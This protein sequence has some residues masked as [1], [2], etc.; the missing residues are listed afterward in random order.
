MTAYRVRLDVLI[1]SRDLDGFTDTLADELLKLDETGDLGGSLAT[2][3]F[4]IWTTVEAAD[5]LDAAS[6]GA[7]NI[8]CAAHAAGGT[9]HT[10]PQSPDEWPDWIKRSAIEATELDAADDGE[11]AKSAELQPA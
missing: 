10:W 6:Q 11:S 7:T 4:S 5:L 9:T 8:R 2:G 1:T 3:L